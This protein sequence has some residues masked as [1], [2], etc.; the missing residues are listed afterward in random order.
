[1]KKKFKR[2]ANR[3]CI[4]ETE[5]TLQFVKWKII[6]SPFVAYY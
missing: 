3:K 2:N 1:M 4:Y 6:T 5:S